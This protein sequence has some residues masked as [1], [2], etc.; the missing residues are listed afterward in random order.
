VIQAAVV[1]A[2][3]T[4]QRDLDHLVGATGEPHV[5]VL[6]DV[7]RFAREVGALDLAPVV[8]RVAGAQSGTQPGPGPPREEKPRLVPKGKWVNASVLY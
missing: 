7:G 6:V 2:L 1:P 4:L 8:G 3:P 5:A